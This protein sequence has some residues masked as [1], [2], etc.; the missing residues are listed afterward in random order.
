MFT[1]NSLVKHIAVWQLL[2]QL[3]STQEVLSPAIFI[4]STVTDFS[5]PVRTISSYA[6]FATSLIFGSYNYFSIV[7]VGLSATTYA[8]SNHYLPFQTANCRG[9]RLDRRTIVN[10]PSTAGATYYTDACGTIPS[11][12]AEVNCVLTG[13][14]P[15]TTATCTMTVSDGINPVSTFTVTEN[16][17]EIAPEP[18]TITAGLGKLSQ[19]GGGGTVT[20]SLTTASVNTSKFFSIMLFPSFEEKKRVDAEA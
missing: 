10:G 11:A 6:P 8:S 20:V 12:T 7:A 3:V 1:T 15:V 13:P 17:S 19:F 9:E 2:S 14:A 4:P 16:S 18:V 5:V